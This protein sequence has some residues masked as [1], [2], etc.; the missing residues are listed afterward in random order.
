MVLVRRRLKKKKRETSREKIEVRGAK[1]FDKEKDRR[2]IKMCRCL[3]VQRY[4]ESGFRDGDILAN[5]R[6]DW[7]QVDADTRTRTKVLD[8]IL[9]F[10]PSL[11]ITIKDLITWLP[12]QSDIQDM[13]GY[14]FP[15]LA[16]QFAAYVE[17]NI[18]PE[19]FGSVLKTDCRSMHE[20]WLEFY[21]RE[22]HKKVWYFGHWK[23]IQ[24][25]NAREQKWENAIPDP[26]VEAPEFV[27]RTDGR[28]LKKRK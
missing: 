14:D 15:F 8:E 5:F 27:L 3:E 4:R 10:A 20:F 19:K 1:M 6:E 2:Y 13:L 11:T 28:K 24:I 18:E 9:I 16:R 25:W 22:R 12:R 23:H 17:D 7:K 21:M 26:F